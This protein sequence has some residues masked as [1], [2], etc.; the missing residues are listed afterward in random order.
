M[1]AQQRRHRQH[2]QASAQ[3]NLPDQLPDNA[4][5]PSAVAMPDPAL[6]FG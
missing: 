6:T 1:I 2:W 3:R 4:A 5:A